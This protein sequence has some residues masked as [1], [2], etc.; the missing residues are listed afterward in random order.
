ML[1]NVPQ[2]IDVEDKIVGPLTA[3]QLGWLGGLF[4]VGAAI[5]TL[6]SDKLVAILAIL[7]LALFCT[8]AAFYRPYGQPFLGFLVHAAFYMFKPK[9]YVW[10]R[11][12]EKTKKAPITVIKKIT[13]EQN[14]KNPLE[15][16]HELARSL[17]SGGKERSDKLVEMLKQKKK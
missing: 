14:G 1:F 13:A 12:A 15:D 2:N 8:A 10:K 11:Y 6:S 16:I 17:D 5:W 7:P 3:K 9:V 4:G